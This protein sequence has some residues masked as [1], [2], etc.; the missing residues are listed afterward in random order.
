[1]LAFLVFT[2]V[3]IVNKK[4][5]FQAADAFEDAFEEEEDLFSSKKKQI[6]VD[7]APSP[8][9]SKATPTVR[10]SKAPSELFEEQY[11][12]V[13]PR[14]GQSPS[15]NH[16]QVRSNAIRRLLHHSNNAAQLERVAELLVAWR[17]GGRV[18][19]RDTVMEFIGACITVLIVVLC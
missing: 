9:S 3:A 2:S 4:R 16:P 14:I 10:R 5:S 1:M 13:S 11:A 19:D 12:F 6:E 7:V 17:N 8:S 15:I 18:V